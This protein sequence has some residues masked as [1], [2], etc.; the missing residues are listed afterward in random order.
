MVKEFKALQENEE[1]IEL[2]TEQINAYL[3]ELGIEG[4]IGPKKEE[5]TSFLGKIFGK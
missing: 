4:S 5:K 2:I 1:Q 3:K